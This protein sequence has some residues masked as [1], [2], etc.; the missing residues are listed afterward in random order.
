MCGNS[1]SN[2]SSTASCWRFSTGTSSVPYDAAACASAARSRSPIRTA[3]AVRKDRRNVGDRSK[4]PAREAPASV[5][6]RV[7]WISSEVN[8]SS[9]WSMSTGVPTT[10]AMARSSSQITFTRLARPTSLSSRTFSSGYGLSI[11]TRW[12]LTSIDSS[13]PACS[14]ASSMACLVI[15]SCAFAVNVSASAA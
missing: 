13:A 15:R 5:I 10:V 7:A 11:S 2:S 3:Y 4:D 6:A 12:L 1:R 14:S 8:S 9:T